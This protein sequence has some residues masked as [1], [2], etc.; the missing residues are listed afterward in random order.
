MTNNAVSVRGLTKHYGPIK[1]VRGIDLDV[2]E[3]EMFGFLGPNGAGKTALRSW[4]G[5]GRS[6]RLTWEGP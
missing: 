6:A 2:A 1:A 3:R 5:R 4:P